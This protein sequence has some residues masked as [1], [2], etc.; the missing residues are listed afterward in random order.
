[1][2]RGDCDEPWF[3]GCTKDIIIRGGSYISPVEVERVLLSHP[4]V[5]DAAVFGVPD[6]VLGQRV[7]AVV[8]LSNGAGE[9]ALGDILRDTRQQ[10]A[11]NKVPEAAVGCRCR[12]A[13]LAGQ[14]RPRGG[15]DG[16]ARQGGLMANIAFVS[17]YF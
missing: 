7:A 3:A 12:A 11:D 15:G 10:L 14:G 2:R 6:P 1:M 17:R 16:D 8:R 13:Q 4:L 5:Q 9:A